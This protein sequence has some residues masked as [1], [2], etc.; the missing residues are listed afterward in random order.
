MENNNDLKNSL[1]SMM[2]GLNGMV[3]ALDSTLN[4]I[5]QN[6]TTE[7]AIEFSKSMQNANISDKLKDFNKINSELKKEFGI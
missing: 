6:M 5:K 2:S 4:G 7:Q 3:K 1:D